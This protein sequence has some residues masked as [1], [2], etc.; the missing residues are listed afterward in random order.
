MDDSGQVTKV[1][2][3]LTHTRSTSYDANHNQLTAVTA[4]GTGSQN[5]TTFG[6]DS[7]D[8]LT[9]AKLPTG[10]TT[11]LG[12]YSTHSGANLPSSLTTPSGKKTSYSCDTSGNLM[13]SQDT[14]PGV[15]NGAKRSPA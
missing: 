1:V 3:A 4:Q 6:W 15:S 14:T 5:T 9:S 2:D 10:A 11:A 13:S 8:N 7:S 12:A